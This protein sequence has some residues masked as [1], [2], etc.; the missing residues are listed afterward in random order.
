MKILLLLIKIKVK[1][2]FNNFKKTKLFKI[3]Q[4]V[5]RIT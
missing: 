2:Y 1:K 5:R 3:Q 4:I